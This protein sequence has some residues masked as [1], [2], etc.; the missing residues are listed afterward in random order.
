[1]RT[2]YQKLKARRGV[3]RVVAKA[4]DAA[5]VTMPLPASAAVRCTRCRREATYY[6]A[7]GSWKHPMD[8]QS[9]AVWRHRVVVV[10]ASDD[11]SAVWYFPHVVTPG[12]EG[13]GSCL[14]LYRHQL[15][16]NVGVAECATCGTQRRHELQWPGDAFYRVDIGRACLWAA[17]RADMIELRAYI[18]SRDRRQMYR[19]GAAHWA[20]RYLPREVIVAKS[21]ERVVA[22]IDVL[23][24]RT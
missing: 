15:E 6:T 21:R 13:A 7:V 14:S 2:V 1:M 10:P 8:V 16:R 4:D 22:A 11:W 17:S 3:P 12:T 9:A 18:V 20:T 24:A 23:L 19:S 5:V